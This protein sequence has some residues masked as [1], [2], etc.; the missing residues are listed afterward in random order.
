MTY[1]IFEFQITLAQFIT[2]K[3]LYNR[4]AYRLRFLIKV[5]TIITF[6]IPKIFRAGINDFA[7][8]V[9]QHGA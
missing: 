2:Q 7:R 1:T 6:V 5:Y 3:S 8:Q 4:A 9:K